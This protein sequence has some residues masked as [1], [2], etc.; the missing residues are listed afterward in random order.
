[1]SNSLVR[2]TIICGDALDVLKTLPDQSVHMCVTSPPYW[3]LRDYQVNGQVGLESCP[4]DYIDRLVAVFRE[5]RRVLR[6]DGTL[7]LNLGDS[8]VGSGG[9]GQWLERGGHN[10]I[11]PKGKNPNRRPIGGLKRKDLVGIP[12]RVALALQEDGWWLRSDCIW[13]KPN[14]LPEAVQDRFTRC[15]EYVFLL[16]KSEHYYCDMDAVREPYAGS[17]NPDEVYTGQATKRYE[18]AKAQNPSDVKRRVLESMQRNGGRNRRTVW[19]VTVKPYRGAHFATFPEELVEVP[20]LA[21]TSPIVCPVCGAPWRRVRV[22]TG[23]RNKREAFPDSP[24]RSRTKTDS[25][26]WRPTSMPTETF[27]R[28]CKCDGNDGSGRAI[29]LDPFIGSGTTAVVAERLGRDYLGIELNKTYIDEVAMP[30]IMRVT[31]QAKL[32]EEVF[33]GQNQQP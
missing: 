16:S 6:R 18:T 2:N 17:S 33:H 9:P 31:K 20:I 24:F 4:F 14:C 12:W 22:S 19:R 3:G 30:R 29:V 28:G 25:T 23:A 21:G 11:G 15:H 7:W 10:S 5:V 26:G 1:M 32:F 8:Y 27:G 13:Y